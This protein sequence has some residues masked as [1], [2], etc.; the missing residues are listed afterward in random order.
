MEQKRGIGDAAAARQAALVGSMAGAHEKMLR[1]IYYQKLQRGHTRR[2]EQENQSLRDEVRKLQL[3]RSAPAQ[4]AGIVASMS[5]AHEAVLRDAYYQKLQRGNV[6]KLTHEN[7]Q[8]RKQVETSKTTSQLKGSAPAMQAGILASMAKAHE[9]MLREVYYQKLRR[10]KEA[11]S[12]PA[13]PV[14]AQQA[15]IL[16]SMAKSH[17]KMLREIYYQKLQRG[18]AK[19]LEHENQALKR[20]VEELRSSTSTSTARQAGIVASMAKSHET[21]LR[22]IYY[23]KLQRGQMAKLARENERLRKAGGGG[24]SSA[25]AQQAGILASMAKSHETMLREIYYQ[26]LQRG[27]TAKLERENERLRKAGGGR[28][29]PAQQA[30]ILAS[31][32]KSHETML[33]EIYYQKLQRGRVAKLERENE[34]LRKAGGARSAPAQQAGILA[35]MAKSHETMLREI[36]YQKLQRGRMAKLERENERLRKAGGGRSAPAQQAGILA[37]MAKSHETMLREIY[38]Q[39]LQRGRTK[40]VEHENASLRDQLD[41][42]RKKGALKRSATGQQ[43]GIVAS[44]SK[45]HEKMLREIYYQK[46]QRG[47]SKRL[48]QQVQSLQAELAAERRQA[49]LKGSATAGRAG[50]L[51]SMAKSHE[52]MLREVYYQKL[53]RKRLGKPVGP[54]EL[55]RIRGACR[56]FAAQAEKVGSLPDVSDQEIGELVGE[57]KELAARLRGFAKDG[58]SAEAEEPPPINVFASD[59]S[60]ASRG[61]ERLVTS[62]ATQSDTTGQKPVISV[63]KDRVSQLELELSN[64]KASHAALTEA[65]AKLR[66]ELAAFE[67]SNPPTNRPIQSA[68]TAGVVASMAKAHEAMLREVYYLRLKRRAGSDGVATRRELGALRDENAALKAASPQQLVAGEN[69]RLRVRVDG[70]ERALQATQS[71]AE[72]NAVQRQQIVALTNTTGAETE[73]LQ[74]ENERLRGQ[75]EQ[76]DAGLRAAGSLEENT[77]ENK[78]LR[79]QVGSAPTKREPALGEQSDEVRSLQA[80]VREL[81]AAL[82]AALR[83]RQESGSIPYGQAPHVSLATTWHDKGGEPV[84]TYPPYDSPKAVPANGPRN[85]TPQQNRRESGATAYGM[86]P[87]VSLATTCQGGDPAAGRQLYESPSTVP[88][89]SPRHLTPQSRRGS[90]AAMYG[91]TPPVSLAA[92]GD[93][94]AVRQPY[95]SPSTVPDSSPRHLAQSRR[96]SGA[97]MYGKTPP[98]SLAAG[99]DPAPARPPYESPRTVPE[100]G[101]RMLTQQQRDELVQQQQHHRQKYQEFQQRIQQQDFPRAGSPVPLSQNAYNPTQAIPRISP[102]RNQNAQ[103]I[104]AVPAFDCATTPKKQSSL[105][106]PPAPLVHTPR[107]NYP[108]SPTSRFDRKPSLEPPNNPTTTPMS[109]YRDFAGVL[110]SPHVYPVGQ[111]QAALQGNGRLTARVAC[112]VHGIKQN[113]RLSFK[114]VPTMTT[115]LNAVNAVYEVIARATHPAG[116]PDVPF[117]LAALQVFDAVSQRWVNLTDPQMIA[118]DAQLFCFQHASVW[119]PDRPG[120]IPKAEDVETWVA[121]SSAP[122]RTL[123]SSELPTRAVMAATVFKDMNPAGDGIVRFADLREKLRCCGVELVGSTPSELFAKIDRNRDSMITT[124]EWADFCKVQPR[125]LEAIY[126]NGVCGKADSTPFHL[127]QVLGGFTGVTPSRS[128]RFNLTPD[129]GPNTSRQPRYR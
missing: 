35:S 117:S 10:G 124:D 53:Q 126:I 97:A 7:E 100:N 8:L 34:R 50:V 29:A 105:L 75:V 9:S 88:D 63:L 92:G 87:H 19:R 33:R 99:G 38:Y 13:R 4:Q 31:M 43:A 116:C 65:N 3:K 41:A 62:L 78:S 67:G 47:R 5:K 28:S 6:R 127:P 12:Q 69:K 51:A 103:P 26:K 24:K 123:S 71:L 16:A 32:A 54:E 77:H 113:V 22:E 119:H 18:R 59:S 60:V 129:A 118:P 64:L 102:R 115:L 25:P 44:M 48:E 74:Q 11:R 1:E 121:A 45:A 85:L 83:Q 86:V 52:A 94:A 27:R 84:P 14:P 101:S 106:P 108:P 37:S 122:K 23:Q 42:E 93:P 96:E 56:R 91:R 79:A 20:L 40:R 73:K 39:K 120:T 82:N 125:L 109:M 81:E 58:G 89:N 72:E 17:E 107:H 104:G 90:G 114:P 36:Y 98:V 2:M 30:G 128:D 21:M 66:L 70:L 46:L 68:K 55:A 15:G 57:A 110:P 95:E 76:L 49:A 80:R 61:Y 112:D 111:S